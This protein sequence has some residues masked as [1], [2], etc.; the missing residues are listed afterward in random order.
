[1]AARSSVRT[2]ARAL[3]PTI[4]ELPRDHRDVVHALAAHLLSRFEQDEFEPFD[5]D[6]RTFLT[7]GYMQR[8]LREV[9]ARCTGE[10]TA[11]AALRWLCS[12]GILEDTGEVKK[13]RHRVKRAAAREKF[14]RGEDSGSG[15]G[16]RDAQPSPSRSYWWPIYRVIPLGGVVEDIQSSRGCVRT[17]PRG[18]AA[19][20][21]SVRTGHSSR[22]DFTTPWTLGFPSRFGAVRIQVLR[23][24]IASDLRSPITT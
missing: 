2:L 21:V 24:A 17:A 7:V 1:V 6:G 22:A 11:A 15:E 19:S 4:E 8:R 3:V 12:S 16:G 18:S 9:G 13:P 5:D 23:P 10:K 20:S 14:Q